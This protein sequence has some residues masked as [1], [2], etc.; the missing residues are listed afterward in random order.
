MVYCIKLKKKK[1]LNQHLFP[2]LNTKGVPKIFSNLIYSIE[3]GDIKSFLQ[4]IKNDIQI[5]TV[6]MEISRNK[7]I[8]LNFL[9]IIRR[10][11]VKK[12]IT[13]IFD[14]C[15]SGFRENF[16]GLH[17]KIN[18][19]PDLVTFGKALGNGYAI[20]AVLG[21]KKIMNTFS[22]TFISST[23]WT[24]RS[25]YVAALETLRIMKKTKPWLGIIKKGIKIKENWKKLSEKY[26][27]PIK[28]FGLDAI[29]S[30][31]FENKENNLIYKTFLTQEFLKKNILASNMIYISTAH[32]KK[33]ID[34]YFYN[35]EKIFKTISS[36]PLTV[37]KK[38]IFGRICFN[39]MA[40]MN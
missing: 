5:G 28:I 34:K 9:K 30:F 6:I 33:H 36:S 13:L 23:F 15:T 27:V 35:L 31:S 7:K 25:G 11:T 26:S 2:N 8:D 32:K 4:I 17:K 38:K 3:Y 22:D 1:N 37:I 16:G 10:E 19:F 12:G 40:R 20:T 39:S 21:K 29:P 18:I 14:E 24:E